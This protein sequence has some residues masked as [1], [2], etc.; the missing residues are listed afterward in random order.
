M[1]GTG[2]T[3]IAYLFLAPFF[4][5]FGLF[6]VYPLIG[7]MTLAFFQTYGARARVFVG[8]GNFAFL[9][10]DGDFRKAV[11]NTLTF[12]AASLFIQLPISLGL[13]LLLDGVASRARNGLRL[14]LVSP[15]LVGSIFVGLLF[16]VLFAPRHGLINRA[17]HAAFGWGLEH[18]WLEQPALVMPALVLASLWMYVGFNMVFFLAALQAVDKDLDEAARVD[19]AN[20]WTRFRHVTWP[21]IR[22]VAGF[23]VTMSLI[24]SL[25]LFELPLG[26][27]YGNNGYG[28]DGAAL[29]MLT[30]L[31]DVAFNRGDLGLGSAVAWVLAALVL[32][33]GLARMRIAAFMNRGGTP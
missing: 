32:V 31:N 30:Y 20:T 6:F 10:Q 9:L 18:R 25:Q 8:L 24:G 22:P 1:K 11:G 7:A 33:I 29:T 5:L 15:N 4:L 13:A 21:A 28:P 3:R 17:L 26:L 16:G 2:N 27:F 12:A 14:A 23:I 19:G